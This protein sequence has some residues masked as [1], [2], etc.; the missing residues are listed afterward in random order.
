MADNHNASQNGSI[1]VTVAG[2]LRMIGC[3]LV[4]RP[5]E[6]R[7]AHLLDEIQR[8]TT[9]MLPDERNEFLNRLEDYFPA[10]GDVI[11]APEDE[12]VDRRWNDPVELAKQL[13]KLAN[14]PQARVQIL[15][16]MREQGLATTTVSETAVRSLRQVLAIPDKNPVEA[17]RLLEVV[18]ELARFVTTI[19]DFAFNVWKH[20]ARGSDMHRPQTLK[21]A[22]VKFLVVPDNEGLRRTSTKNDLDA[23]LKA[24]KLRLQVLLS[25]LRSYTRKHAA[26]FAPAEIISHVGGG[27]GAKK[28]YWDRYV[29]MCG[30]AEQEHVENEITRTIASAISE[31]L[32][33]MRRTE[34]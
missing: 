12:D 4:D 23:Q 7:S 31:V 3:E 18:S 1:P 21:D 30:G 24:L 2:R 17:N 28:N 5:S 33:T 25:A 8:S 34:T 19:D 27:F 29:E 16:L 9:Q 26:K 11:K 6:E 22:L 10:W 13:G 15:N 20:S 14:T 32:D